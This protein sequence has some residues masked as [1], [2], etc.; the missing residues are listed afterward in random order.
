MDQTMLD[1]RDVPDAE[2]GD[3]VVVFGPHEMLPLGAD[4]LANSI[5]TISYEILTSVSDRVPRVYIR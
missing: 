5:N 4:H 1:V 3:E 2:E